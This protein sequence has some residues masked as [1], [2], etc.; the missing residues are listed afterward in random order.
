MLLGRLRFAIFGFFLSLSPYMIVIVM[1][2]GRKILSS[3]YLKFSFSRFIS[4]PATF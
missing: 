3:D 4:K 2:T 1:E